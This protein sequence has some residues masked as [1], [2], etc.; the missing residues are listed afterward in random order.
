[1]LKI[2][3]LEGGS[4]NQKKFW[5]GDIPPN[6]AGMPTYELVPALKPISTSLFVDSTALLDFEEVSKVYKGLVLRGGK[7]KKDL[8]SSIMEHHGC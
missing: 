3:P 1:M 7:L 4:R 8:W 2:V 6:S 5:G